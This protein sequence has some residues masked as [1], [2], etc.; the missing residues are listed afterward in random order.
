[1]M[2]E[3]IFGPVLPV[4]SYRT[5]DEVVN[6]VNDRPR[7]LALYSFGRDRRERRELLTKTTSGGVGVNEVIIHAATETLPFGGIGASGMGVYHG[8]DGFRQL[9]H[10]RAVLQ[11]PRVSLWRLLGLRPPYGKRLQWMTKRE[12]RA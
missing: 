12:L 6:F 8:I 1:M 10:P 2:R 5:L 9:S 7:P 3:E 11:A 4:V